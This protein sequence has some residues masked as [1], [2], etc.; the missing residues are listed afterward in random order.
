MLFEIHDGTVTAGTQTVLRHIH[1]EIHGTEK[2]AV[3]GPNGAGKTTLL[4]LIAGELPLDRDDRR[5]GPGMTSSRTL[6]VGMLKQNI[7]DDTSQ[8]VLS[9]IRQMC[10]EFEPYSRERYD[11]ER[12][13]DRIFTGFGFSMADKNK[14]LKA[15]SGG[16]RTKIGLIRLLM[17]KPDILLLDEPTNHLDTDCVEWLERYLKGY[18]KAVVMVSH[19]RF[20]LDQTAEVVYELSEGSLYRYVGNYTAYRMQKHKKLLADMKAYERQQEEIARQKA[21]IERFK[22]KPRKAAFARSRRRLLERMDMKPRPAADDRHIFT[23]DIL[24]KMPGS[25]WV[26][27]CEHLKPGYDRPLLELDWR[28][29]RGQKVGLIG[30]NGAGKSTFLKIVAGRLKP[31]SGKL[32]QGKDITIGY[33]DQH[34][35]EIDSIKTVAEHFHDSFPSMTEKEVRQTLGA[36]LFAGD[37]ANRRVCDLSGGEKARLVLCELLT[38]RPNFLVLDEPTNHM[39]IPARETLES[40]FQAYKGTILCVSHDRYFISRVATELLIF[41]NGQAVYYPFGYEH[42]IGRR[43]QAA[44]PQELRAS[45]DAHQASLVEG[46]K[47]VPKPEHH[48]LREIDTEEAYDEWRLRL[49]AEAMTEAAGRTQEAWEQWQAQQQ[50]WEQSEEI[51]FPEDGRDMTEIRRCAAR[52]EDLSRQWQETCCQWYDIYREITQEMQDVSHDEAAF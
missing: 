45:M 48:R 9:I 33:F 41:E 13:F 29:R 46:L 17:Q 20:F 21:L 1:F 16:E 2:I 31:L 49:A 50:A 25:K 22:H 51:F 4:R 37:M 52:Y 39:D 47:A 43:H 5:Q 38:A 30:P 7:F 6:S 18:E 3:V 28:L 24:P 19:D 42:Y 8:T 15:F 40:A 12:E 14:Q 23:G 36:Y 34:S 26:F 35:T 11:C 27:E 44:S 32:I 10:A